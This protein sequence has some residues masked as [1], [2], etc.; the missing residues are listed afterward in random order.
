MMDKSLISLLLLLNVITFS[1]S[2]TNPTKNLINDVLK[3]IDTATIGPEMTMFFE[4]FEGLG[5]FYNQPLVMGDKN[6]YETKKSMVAD[7]IRKNTNMIKHLVNENEKKLMP[8]L[9]QDFNKSPKPSKA[10]VYKPQWNGEDFLT[11]KFAKYI[12]DSKSLKDSHKPMSREKNHFYT[13]NIRTMPLKK[14]S[15]I[16]RDVEDLE[17]MEDW[18]KRNLKL[19]NED[20][21][22]QVI[23]TIA[24]LYNGRK[25]KP[26]RYQIYKE[27]LEE[28]EAEL[29]R[30]RQLEIK[31]R[32]LE[33]ELQEKKDLVNMLE[34]KVE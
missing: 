10:V 16:E 30:K 29:Y 9:T 4:Q 34:K 1:H 17:D 27:K 13:K 19:N 3:G 28:K 14:N 20:F 23:D 18:N 5:E 32:E 11:Q 31:L 25:R 15:V 12:S 26:N 24:K 7:R 22:K 2:T 6:E 8:F 33:K 21:S